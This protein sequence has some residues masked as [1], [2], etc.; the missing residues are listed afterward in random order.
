MND[1]IRIRGAREHNLKNLNLEFPRNKLIVITYATPTTGENTIRVS[2]P[3][4]FESKASTALKPTYPKNNTA[5][6]QRCARA[7]C[8]HPNIEAAAIRTRH[9]LGIRK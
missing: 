9:A 3:R 6:H 2:L 5:S 7:K 4:V 1:S 8:A